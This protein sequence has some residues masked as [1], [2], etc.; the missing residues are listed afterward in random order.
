MK[1]LDRFLNKQDHGLHRDHADQPDQADQADQLHRPEQPPPPPSALTLVAPALLAPVAPATPQ[2]E[3][4]PEI[5]AAAQEGF[6]LFPIVVGSLQA[7]SARAFLPA[8]TNVI[9]ELRELAS[10]HPGCQFGMVVN[11]RFCALRMEGEFGFGQFKALAQ[12][13]RLTSEDDAEDGE[14]GTRLLFGGNAVFAIYLSPERERPRRLP[15]LGIGL[16][17][18]REWVP[19]PGAEFKGDVYR[20]IDPAARI[21]LLPRFLARLVFG[22]PEAS[23]ESRRVLEFPSWLPR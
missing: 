12:R 1:F 11:G 16:S 4:P 2:V 15:D 10:Q 8:A 14:W 3:L 21:E 20:Y 18:V 13:A 9:Q 19:A 23:M 7:A 22:N 17:I 5:L 6:S